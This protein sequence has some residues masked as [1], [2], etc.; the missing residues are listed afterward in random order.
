MKIK[1]SLRALSEM[2]EYLLETARISP[3]DGR[4][5]KDGLGESECV[6]YVEDD[7]LDRINWRRR[8]RGVLIQL[9]DLFDRSFRVW[10]TGFGRDGEDR[11]RFVESCEEIF[12]VSAVRF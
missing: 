2:L 1:S 4:M 9:S 11:E 12:L 10:S 7:I 3:T 6:V 8:S 5:V